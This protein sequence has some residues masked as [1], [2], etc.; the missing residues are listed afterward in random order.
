VQGFVGDA[1]GGSF[2]QVKFEFFQCSKCVVVDPPR[3]EQ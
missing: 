3:R 2:T 1:A